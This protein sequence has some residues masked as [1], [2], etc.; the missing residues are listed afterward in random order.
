MG[1]RGEQGGGGK[2]RGEGTKYSRITDGGGEA[3]TALAEPSQASEDAQNAWVDANSK[4]FEMENIDFQQRGQEVAD[5]LAVASEELKDFKRIF[6]AFQAPVLPTGAQ[7][8]EARVK[9]GKD[10]GKDGRRTAG[11]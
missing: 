1:P 9:E 8:L 4:V 10:G 3:V 7:R 6:E 2:R 11:R 5:R